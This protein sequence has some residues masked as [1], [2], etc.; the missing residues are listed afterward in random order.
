LSAKTR[1]LYTPQPE[2]FAFSHV[3]PR[4]VAICIKTCKIR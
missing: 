2:P 3:P 1:S 4:E